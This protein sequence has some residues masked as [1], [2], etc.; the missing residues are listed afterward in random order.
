ML[1]YLSLLSPL[2][3][4]GLVGFSTLL[5]NFI[6]FFIVQTQKATRDHSVIPNALP[7]I[8]RDK[9]EIFSSVR[10]NYRGLVN[11][12]QLF[13]AGYQKYS[14]LGLIYVVPAW[15]RGPQII[16][17][18]SMTSW[19]A[20]IPENILSAKECTFDNVQF[21]YTVGHPEIL[22]S[23]LIGVLIRRELTRSIGQFNDEIFEEIDF[24]MQ[25]IF[26]TDG[27]WRKVGIYDSF[28]Q[29]VGSSANRI[30]VGKEL[31]S[32]MDFIMASVKFAKDVSISSY[33][34]HMFPKALK[35]LASW[36][37]TIPNRYHSGIAM[38]YIR[39]LVQQRFDDMVRKRDDPNF[40]F[41]EPDDFVTWMVREALKRNTLIE[42]SAEALAY[43]IVLLNFAAITTTTITAT[44][45]LLDIHSAHNA[46]E[47]VEAL[48]EEASVVLREHNGVW[49]KQA[50]SKLYRLDSAIRESARMSGI[51]GTAMARKV[52]VPGGMTLPDGT[53]VP[54]NVTIGVA[55]DGIH[56]DEESYENPLKFDPFR[57]S[58]PREQ[59]LAGLAGDKPPVN[60][61]FVTTS[62][63]WLPFGHG[64]HGCPGR[65]FASNN[66]KMMLAH[67]LLNYEVQ[68]WKVRPPNISID[69]IS[70]VPMQATMMV[71]RRVA[72]A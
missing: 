25:S 9:N 69:V 71:R 19:I 70:V 67:L 47:L 53:W 15:T 27:Q 54:E 36:F 31:G 23:D 4:V 1:D 48:R 5:L 29:T 12:V 14:K 59:Y 51:G 10:S 30:F 34:I 6:F 26:G 20:N 17:P 60:E 16:I 41:E 40:S 37:A 42:T 68:P 57:F 63:R 21:K 49:T 35:P 13:K 3:L 28:I 62:E 52:K 33:I 18:P 61:D 8:G 72:K 56:F 22:H 32:N 66:L 58:R 39:P 65:F 38:K 7:W 24:S 45:S 44:N 11:S 64:I 46:E 2:P 50:I 43:G 55:M